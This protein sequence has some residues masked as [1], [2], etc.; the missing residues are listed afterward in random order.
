VECLSVRG[1]GRHGWRTTRVGTKVTS[2]AC[3]ECNYA[4][5]E[6][7]SEASQQLSSEDEQL[8]TAPPA[9]KGAK[10]RREASSPG[11][12]Q[13]QQSPSP[14]RRRKVPHRS[15]AKEARPERP[16]SAE[17]R[18]YAAFKEAKFNRFVHEPSFYQP[19]PVS[20]VSISRP[21]AEWRGHAKGVQ[22]ERILAYQANSEK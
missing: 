1:V 21:R 9:R 14:V 19:R 20:R 4:F 8:T 13:R 11:R 15:A 10:S 3:I 5:S 2:C 22:R 18:E 17:L 16:S 7:E 12:K 6:E